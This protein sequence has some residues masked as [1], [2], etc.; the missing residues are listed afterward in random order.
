MMV[1]S[2][3]LRALLFLVAESFLTWYA[4]DRMKIRFPLGALPPLCADLLHPV[5]DPLCGLDSGNGLPVPLHRRD[6]QR[7][8]LAGIDR[9]C[10]GGDPRDLASESS[11]FLNGNG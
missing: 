3:L 8:N 9:V 4:A 11:A 5:P 10:A 7:K 1:I 6:D 2:F